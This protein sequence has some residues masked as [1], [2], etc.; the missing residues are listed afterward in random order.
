M[1]TIQSYF[2]R[3][4][5]IKEQL[6]AVDEE[7]ENAEIVMTTLNGLP[8]SWDSFIQGICARRKLITFSIL[9]EECSQ[10]EAQIVAQ[11]ENMGNEDQSLTTHTNK[12]KR[13]NYH[14]KKGKHPP[15]NQ[16]DNPRRSSRDL[17]NVRCYT[18][19][20]KGHFSRDCPRNKGGSHKKK[21]N[22]RRHHAHI[23][24][25]DEPPRK[26]FKEESEDSSSD[27]EYVLISSLTGNITHGSNGWLIDSG[28]SKNM[29]GF[30][31]SFVNLSEHES[32][33]K[34]KLG[35]D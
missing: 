7:V 33:H 18:C 4:S 14:L 19:D 1:G 17:S 11:E 20:E 3:V 10:E 24:E 30:K 15:Q 27:E 22:K 13:E 2:K 9:W 23:A 34:V 6:E 31:E 29:L 28:A 16:K 25:D 35:D 5:Q 8:R 21:N 26:R 32:P 12:I